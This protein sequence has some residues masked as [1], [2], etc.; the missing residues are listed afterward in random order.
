MPHFMYNISVSKLHGKLARHF[1][2]LCS[3]LYYEKLVPIPSYQEK[4]D[5]LHVLGHRWP[6][7]CGIV[8]I[9]ASEH[10]FTSPV[11]KC[12]ELTVVLSN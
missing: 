2:I 1:K 11:K 10:C 12:D 4:A 5:V 8:A 6:K 3:K 9:K 7:D